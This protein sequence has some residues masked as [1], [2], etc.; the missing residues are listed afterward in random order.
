MILTGEPTAAPCF[1]YLRVVRKNLR[2]SQKNIP[3]LYLMKPVIELGSRFSGFLGFF[4][5]PLRILK[6]LPGGFPFFFCYFLNKKN[7]FS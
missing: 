6:S 1:G 4:K 2:K 5:N 3:L 7:F